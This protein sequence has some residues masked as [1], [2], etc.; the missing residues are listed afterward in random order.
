M[1]APDPSSMLWL[2]NIFCPSMHKTFPKQRCHRRQQQTSRSC[3]HLCDYSDAG[4]ESGVSYAL[5]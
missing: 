3:Q 5:T 1:A 4:L 2:L